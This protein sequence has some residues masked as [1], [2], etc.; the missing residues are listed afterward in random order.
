MPPTFVSNTHETSQ[1]VSVAGAASSADT[2]HFSP[3]R[4]PPNFEKHRKTVSRSLWA[5]LVGVSTLSVSFSVTMVNLY[6]ERK[7]NTLLTKLERLDKVRASASL[8]SQQ[9]ASWKAVYNLS[10]G[11]ETIPDWVLRLEDFD[12]ALWLDNE[13]DQFKISYRRARRQYWPLK[14]TRSKFRNL[15]ISARL[16]AN[17]VRHDQ[18]NTLIDSEGI[19]RDV[20]LERRAYDPRYRKLR[21][22]IRNLKRTLHQNTRIALI[23]AS[24]IIFIFVVLFLILRLRALD[25]IT[26][27]TRS[28]L[29]REALTHEIGL[30][31]F[32]VDESCAILEINEAAAAALGLCRDV[33]IGKTISD[34]LE[35][36]DGQA[37]RLE[38][39]NVRAVHFGSGRISHFVA[40]PIKLLEIDGSERYTI[41]C[42]DTSTIYELEVQKKVLSQFCHEARNKCASPAF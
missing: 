37:S 4:L 9:Q 3:N 14:S 25:G 26:M 23:V 22:S 31:C 12:S 27:A 18:E 8:N 34:V 39:R 13:I 33:V 32:V 41:I 30:P 19:D 42:H 2:T 21:I 24:V 7:L 29:A 28:F 6:K 16:V 1:A 20:R 17:R 10:N 36:D 11:T 40:H 38:P 35:Y 5:A 15:I